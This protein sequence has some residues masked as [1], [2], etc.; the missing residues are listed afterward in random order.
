MYPTDQSSNFFQTSGTSMNAFNSPE[1]NQSLIA[2]NINQESINDEA[3]Q[4]IAA[5]N[6]EPIV[7]NQNSGTSNQADEIQHSA[8]ANSASPFKDWMYVEPYA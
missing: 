1:V 4:M 2:N 7:I 8:I 3:R 5:G 6:V